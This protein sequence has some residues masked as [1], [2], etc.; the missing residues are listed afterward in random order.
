MLKDNKCHTVAVSAS[1]S[2][3]HSCP[4]ETECDDD[5]SLDAA[6]SDFLY[7]QVSDNVDGSY[8]QG[9]TGLYNHGNTCYVNAT[10]Q[11][12]SNWYASVLRQV[13]FRYAVSSFPQLCV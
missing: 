1:L 11:A 2:G 13:I 4:S 5:E 9:L 10:I 6:E 8:V 3:S 12:L 7:Q